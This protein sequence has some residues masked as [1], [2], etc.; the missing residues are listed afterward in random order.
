[1]KAW[2]RDYAL[3]AEPPTAAAADQEEDAAGD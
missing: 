2:A 3:L 1:M